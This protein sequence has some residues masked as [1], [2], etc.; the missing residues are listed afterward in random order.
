MVCGNPL[1][2]REKRSGT[3]LGVASLSADAFQEFP[4]IMGLRLYASETYA[5]KKDDIEIY[6]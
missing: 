3:K 5:G 1:P 4:Q 2:L 6:N